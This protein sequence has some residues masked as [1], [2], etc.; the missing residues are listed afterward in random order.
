MNAGSLTFAAPEFLWLLPVFIVLAL[1][2]RRAGI[3]SDYAR[4]FFINPAAELRVRHPLT[5]LLPA[6]DTET[7]RPA[8]TTGLITWLV[9]GFIIVA[10]AQPVRIG[11]RVPDPPQQRDITFIV[12]A[13]VSMLLEDYTLHGK[14]VDRMSFL[15]SFL[16]RFVKALKGERISVI[17]FGDSAYTLLPLSKDPDLVR[18][19]IS[20]I[21]ATVAGRF[22]ALSEA[23]TL[24]VKQSSKDTERK[25]L[26][27]LFTDADAST[28]GIA[29]EAAARLAVGAD[30]PLYTIAIG[31]A[32]DSESVKTGATDLL[33]QPANLGLL[34]ELATVTGAQSYQAGDIKA[35]KLAIDDI[36]QREQYAVATPPRFYQTPVYHL[37][38]LFALG[39][40]SLYQLACLGRSIIR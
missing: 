19:M 32:A 30:L 3:H 29:P 9:L 11:S 16:D 26:L 21:K 37:P 25:R 2:W 12:D 5:S 4:F 31:A 6:T 10:L 20:R 7:H 23:I 40:L 35:L 28:D 14:P 33:Y 38:L 13:S 39:L 34:N 24:A 8:W 1:L 18:Y 17:V 15:K 36:N 22:N 27:I